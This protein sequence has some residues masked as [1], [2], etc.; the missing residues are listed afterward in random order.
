MRFQ[1]TTC[2]DL[3]D[4]KTHPQNFRV[5]FGGETG[6]GFCLVIEQQLDNLRPIW[7]GEGYDWGR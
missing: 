5:F 3:N 7:Q 2:F 6:V 4:K 1:Y